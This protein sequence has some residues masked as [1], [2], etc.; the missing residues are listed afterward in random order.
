MKAFVTGGT[1]FIG[2]RVVQRLIEKGHD[3][4]CLVRSP[5][6]AARLRELGA[7]LAQGDVTDQ[8]SMRSCMSGA[9]VVLHIA[10]WYE[11]GL[12]PGADERMERINVGG[13]ENVLGLAVE[14]GIPKIVYTSTV[15]VL[16]DTHGIVV[17]ETYQ[18]ESE[19][20]S[21]YDRT[22]YQAHQVAER[23]IAQGAPVIIVMPA[24]VYGPGDTRMLSTLWQLLL[25]R[26]LP[27][28][29]GADGGFSFVH[30][31]DV[32]QGHVLA[33]ERGQV[34][35][36]YILGGDVMTTGDAIQIVARLA[37]VPSP[38]L[39]LNANWLTP[40]QALASWLEQRV[41]LPP[42]LSSEVMRSLGSTW[43][44]TSAKAERELGY[45]HRSFEEGMAETIT[46]E[47]AQLH[48]RLTFAPG[49]QTKALLA[50]AT[51]VLTLGVILRRG[52]RRHGESVK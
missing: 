27:V 44:V 5:D 10:G 17:D 11:I 32:A 13:T 21:A 8:A 39:L 36:S 23:Y 29:P 35:E 40:W 14:L 12:P 25:R 7:T 1:G 43:M 16:G 38:L 47:A 4:T 31:D 18:R 20:Q 22:K 28:L 52:R 26:M 34:G 19:F 9:D 45:T 50:L 24:A 42:L 30:A 2:R 49:R 48:G 46:W 37:G 15:G 41:V 3:V 51:V 33:L 6:H